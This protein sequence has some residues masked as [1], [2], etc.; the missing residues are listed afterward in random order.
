MKTSTYSILS[1]FQD[2]ILNKQVSAHT[3]TSEFRSKWVLVVI[4]N[5]MSND[6][7]V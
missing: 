1:R 6:E 7:S 3:L 4:E 5:Y 2:L